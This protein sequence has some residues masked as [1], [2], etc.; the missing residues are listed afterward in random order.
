M[1]SGVLA[2]LAVGAV[3][4]VAALAAMLWLM[5]DSLNLTPRRVVIGVFCGLGAVGLVET[6]VK[7]RHSEASR[8]LTAT[9]ALTLQLSRTDLN[10]AQALELSEQLGK[11]L[12]LTQD[13][14]PPADPTSD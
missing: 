10:P 11:A 5:G 13:T 14:Q 4:S 7:P 2:K 3:G 6:V 9:E 1:K 8:V 12:A